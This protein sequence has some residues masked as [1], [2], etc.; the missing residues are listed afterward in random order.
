MHSGQLYLE[1]TSARCN[2]VLANKPQ[3]LIVHGGESDE[4]K[5]LIEQ[6]LSG[7]ISFNPSH[8]SQK[9]IEF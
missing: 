9:D 1:D 4:A 5:H 7:V 2:V 6:R 8:G 3:F